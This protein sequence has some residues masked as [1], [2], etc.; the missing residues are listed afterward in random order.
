MTETVQEPGSHGFRLL[1]AP[2]KFEKGVVKFGDREIKVGG[3]LP[4]L[5]DN[6]KLTRVTSSL[7]PACYKIGR[8]HV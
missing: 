3:P 7:C 8:A 4:K 1:P 5:S 6:E 2:S